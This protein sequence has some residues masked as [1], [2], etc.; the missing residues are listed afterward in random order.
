M[1]QFLNSLK[2]GQKFHFLFL[3]GVLL[4]MFLTDGIIFYS[5]IRAI[6]ADLNNTREQT[7]ATVEYCLQNYIQYPAA[8]ADNI[9]KSSVVEQFLNEQYSSAKDYYDAYFKVHNDLIFGNNMGIN[10]AVVYLYAD[11]PTIVN[12]G[13]FYNISK[14]KES[15]W[16]STLDGSKETSALLFYFGKL[17][18]A[19]SIPRRK[20]LLFKKMDSAAFHGCEK[21]MMIEMNYSGFANAMLGLEV[22][23]DVYVCDGDTIVLSNRSDYHIQEPY[24]KF[25][26]NGKNLY[27]KEINIYGMDLTVNMIPHTDV[28]WSLIVKDSGVLFILVI[29]NLILPFIMMKLIQ[30]SLVNRIKYLQ[31][32]FENVDND[33]LEVIKRVEGNDEVTSLMMSYNR[34]ATRMNELIKTVYKDK[35]REQEIDIARQKAELLALHSQINPHFLF[36]ALE[37]IRMHSLIR[38]EKETA[39]M[40][41]K[42][43]IM[44]RTYVNWGEDLIMLQKEMEFVEAY[45]LLQKY[46][47]GD[48][49]NYEFSVPADCRRCAIPKLTIVTFAEN[50]CVH[51]V[52]SKSTPGWIFVRVFK[53]EGWL[54]IE[55]EDTGGGMEEEEVDEL[56]ERV[57]TVSIQNIREQGHIGMMNAFLR[58]KMFSKN[59]AK[60]ELESEK[61][62]GTTVRISI[63]LGV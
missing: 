39:E 17:S 6:N 21:F 51:G 48:R 55:I 22:D 43:A 45:L 8:I 49:L 19:D 20:V 27:S 61:G 18:A 15:D 42:L 54:T 38:N 7:A 36:N 4:P 46:R 52:E 60:F 25:E 41:G 62:V 50:A 5:S 11:N 30:N 32:S 56:R 2:L 16:Y 28:L 14:A 26:Y 10:D 31:T 53:E 59:R 3:T 34:M 23:Y 58:L 37:S 63:P 47:F 29:V 9:Y 12:G 13:G 35:L 57:E 24:V 33:E 40:V 44:E 1:T